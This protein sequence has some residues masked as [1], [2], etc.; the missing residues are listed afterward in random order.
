[1]FTPKY[2]QIF[3]MKSG[4]CRTIHT[5]AH[6]LCMYGYEAMY[7]LS[8]CTMGYVYGAWCV[9]HAQNTGQNTIGEPGDEGKNLMRKTLHGST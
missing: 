1:M 2:F 6:T 7:S 8:L 5:H 4:K 9:V 3:M